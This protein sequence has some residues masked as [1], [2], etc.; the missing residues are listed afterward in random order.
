[1]YF[2]P[3]SLDQTN[4]CRCKEPADCLTPGI[5]VCVR[6]GEDVTAATQTMSECEAG[7]RQC[8]GEKVSVV[9]I[10]PCAA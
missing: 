3:I 2:Y 7:V 9:G 8:K 1:M 10:L 5:N 4:D 6:V